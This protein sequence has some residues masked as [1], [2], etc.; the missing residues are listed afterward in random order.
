MAPISS[1]RPCA[2]TS[3]ARSPSASLRIAPDSWSTGE[4]VSAAEGIGAGELS[5][6]A[7]ERD[8]ALWLLAGGVAHLGAEV[9]QDGLGGGVDVAVQD[10]LG[11]VDEGGGGGVTAAQ[12][13][14]RTQQDRVASATGLLTASGKAITAAKEAP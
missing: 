9:A 8:R 7:A 3:V 14:L 2:G 1:R 13:T 5:Q 4:L 11:V 12:V 6:L 10:G